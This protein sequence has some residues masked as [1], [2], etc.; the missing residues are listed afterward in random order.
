MGDSRPRR[1]EEF[2]AHEVGLALLLLGLV[3]AQ[4]ALLP[5]PNALTLNP[6]LLL[7]ICQALL[8]GPA[9]AARWAFYGGLSLDVCANSTLGTHALGLLAATLLPALLLARLSRRNWLLPLL[10]V[11]LGALAYY[12]VLGLLTAIL[13]GPLEPRAYVFVV[14][15]PGLLLALAPALPL[16]L[17]MR[18]LRV[19][20]RGEVPVDVY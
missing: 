4:S 5:R 16:F 11:E 19:R 1:I 20:R 17:I 8:A 6:L 18:A 12:A 7:T 3:L 14:V 10:G 2:V 9:S 13:V 15:L